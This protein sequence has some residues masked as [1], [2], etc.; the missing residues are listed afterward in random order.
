MW[1]DMLCLMFECEDRGVL[2]TGGVP[3][4]DEEIAAASTGD[5]SE[6]LSCVTELLRKGVA[7][8][9]QAGA[10]FC[11]RMA[12]DEKERQTTRERV[13]RHRNA[14]CNGDVTALK[15][16]SSSSSS[17][18]GKRERESLALARDGPEDGES[19][20]SVVLPP[21]TRLDFD[22][23]CSMR[24]IPP[25]C[26]EWF[27]NTYE[28]RGWLDAKGLPVRKVEPLLLN[29]MKVWRANKFQQNA[30]SP[31][32]KDPGRLS[33]FEIKARIEAIDGELSEIAN[34]GNNYAMGWEPANDHDRTRMAE[35][36][37]KRKTLRGLLTDG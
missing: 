8:R 32:T 26:A 18:S 29:A 20:P 9:N 36:K 27:W 3:W 25:E 19:Q 16:P 1:I 7:Y 30:I 15:Q 22:T 23:L 37:K 33:T 2:A 34:R 13:Q 4:T 14:S 11:K 24:A 10:I 17:P 5:I 12:R 6:G 35:L 21:L 31:P 28:G